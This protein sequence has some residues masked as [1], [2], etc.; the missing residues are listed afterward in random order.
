[1]SDSYEAKVLTANLPLRTITFVYQ[2]GGPRLCGGIFR[3]E[4]VRT[5]T[6]EDSKV[7]VSPPDDVCPHCGR[8][9]DYS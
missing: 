3:I 4:R 7:F 9:E 6:D 5:V 1:V 2:D 8:P